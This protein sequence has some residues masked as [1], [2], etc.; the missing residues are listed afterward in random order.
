MY[1]FLVLVHIAAAMVWMGGGLYALLLS[2]RSLVVKDDVAVGSF[3]ESQE[4]V[5]GP[6]FAIAPPVALLAGIGLVFWSDAWSFSQNWVY[7]ALALSVVAAVIG[8]GLESGAAKKAKATFDET[9][10]SSPE[11]AAAVQKAHRFGWIDLVVLVAILV[12][13]VFKPGI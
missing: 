8:G 5:N 6:I 3:L 4:K 13:M 1:T 9:G 7:S 11:F 10:S 12:L 2:Q